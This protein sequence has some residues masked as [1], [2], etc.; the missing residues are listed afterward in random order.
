M[1]PDVAREVM[2]DTH[3]KLLTVGA[4][5]DAGIYLLEHNRQPGACLVVL[6]SGQWVEP[7]Q[8]RYRSIGTAAAESQRAPCAATMGRCRPE[9][10]CWL[11][12]DGSARGVAQQEVD[13]VL[14][15]WASSAI[16]ASARVLRVQR[17]SPDFRQA[18]KLERVALS[19]PP[20]AGHVCLR[21]MFA[22]INA[23]DV[24]FADG[25]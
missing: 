4:V 18:T 20:P 14:R 6:S 2:R 5:A 19:L 1:K 25:R 15:A 16:P 9:H 22:G 21:V 11:R 3:S 7:Q 8:T 24:N 10:N 17:L 12:A 13:P 23:S